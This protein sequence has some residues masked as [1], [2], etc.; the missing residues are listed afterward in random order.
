MKHFRC[1][2]FAIATVVALTVTSTASAAIIDVKDAVAFADTTNSSFNVNVSSGTS[3]VLVVGV[4][5]IAQRSVTGITYNGSA[6]TSAGVRQVSETRGNGQATELWYLANPATGTNTLQIALSGSGGN[7]DVAAVVLDDVDLTDL[8]HAVAG[9]N[10]SGSNVAS[11]ST[12]IT[13]SADGSVIIDLVGSNA[14]SATFTTST[15]TKL[16]G[17]NN[18]FALGSRTVDPAAQVTNTWNASASGRTAH[19]LAAFAPVPEPTSLAVVA[20][21]SAIIIPRRN[22]RRRH[23]AAARSQ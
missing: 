17:G 7:Y 10:S 14:T 22:G 3:Q 20:I 13:P 5:L 2:I 19:S 23:G 15:H 21:G 9:N 1:L 6:F 8:P 11:I 4:D 18:G 12:Q 16:L